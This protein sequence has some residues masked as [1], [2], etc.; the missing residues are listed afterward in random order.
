[1]D[2]E[3]AY[4]LR[5]ARIRR[6][7]S[8]RQAI[9]RFEAAGEAMKIAVPARSSLRTLFSMF[10]NGRRAVPDA[11]KPIFRELYR[12]SDDELGFGPAAEDAVGL[13]VPGVPA[14]S[15]D[16]PVP[17]L[18]GFLSAVLDVHVRADAQA[19]PRFLL[20]GV[21]AH[22]L[23]AE[24]LC[25]TARG[26]DREPVLTM[27]V[28]F[29]EFCGWLCQ[30]LGHTDLAANWTSRALEYAQELGDPRLT[31]YVLMRKSN[32]ATDADS[33]GHGLGLANAAL[34]ATRSLTPRIH[35]V[36]LRQRANAHALL[37]DRADCERAVNDALEHA[38][39]GDP[40]DPL[41]G[42]CTPA[43]VEME[44][45]AC[46]DRLGNA[47]AAIEVFEDSLASW[48]ADAQIRDRGLCLARLAA[49]S[50]ACGDS[51]RAWR[52]AGQALPI[53]ASTGSARIRRQLLLASERLASLGDPDSQDLRNELGN[54]RHGDA[55]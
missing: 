21:N 45:A 11:Y 38:A 25:R 16:P 48:P 9:S 42:Y 52:A 33:P 51:P 47:G 36:A 10:E 49:A 50:A 37:G 41:A 30:D 54:L 26:A 7:W 6:G 23:L 53:A 40:A 44:A 19:G 32:I 1:M 15:P 2:D 8:Q 34:R 14:G 18:L 29:T 20:P 35:A 3:S 13:P 5:R 12:A 55:R 31:A 24:Q 22:L 28:R 43:Y 4:P 27:A 39:N 46:W 17:E